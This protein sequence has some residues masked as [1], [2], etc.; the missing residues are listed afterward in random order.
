M[1][2]DVHVYVHT[3]VSAYLSRHVDV[4]VCFTCFTLST[5]AILTNMWRPPKSISTCHQLCGWTPEAEKLPESELSSLP[6]SLSLSGSSWPVPCDILWTQFFLEI[7]VCCALPDFK[8]ST[9]CSRLLKT[10]SLATSNCVLEVSS[11]GL[12]NQKG[13]C[14]TWNGSLE[15]RIYRYLQISTV[16][17]HLCSSLSLSLSL[18]ILSCAQVPYCVSRMR[19]SFYVAWQSSRALSKWDLQLILIRDYPKPIPSHTYVKFLASIGFLQCTMLTKT[20]SE[21]W[22]LGPSWAPTWET[23]FATTLDSKH[24]PKCRLHQFQNS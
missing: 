21:P 14:N 10:D 12:Q 2:V 7:C 11:N 1:Y 15:L 6:L 19:C 23:V 13:L 9:L 16:S 20:S 24:R 8:V 3:C 18:S 5:C 4:Y 22:V 17:L